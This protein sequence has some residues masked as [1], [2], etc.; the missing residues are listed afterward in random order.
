MPVLCDAENNLGARAGS[1]YYFRDQ[2]RRVPIRKEHHDKIAD[3]RFQTRKN[4]DLLA[5]LSRQP[6][7][8]DAVEF[9]EQWSDAEYRV[10][11]GSIVY[12]NEFVVSVSALKHFHDLADKPGDDCPIVRNGNHYRCK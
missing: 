11:F 5:E 10:V 1:A 7:Q 6:Y 4:G 9:T 2:F 8:A 3:H 12:Q